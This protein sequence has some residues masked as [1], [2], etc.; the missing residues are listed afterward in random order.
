MHFTP[1][2]QRALAGAESTELQAVQ[3]LLLDRYIDANEDALQPASYREGD[4]ISQAMASEEAK[5][6]ARGLNEA[7]SLIQ[8]AMAPAPVEKDSSPA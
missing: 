4:G 7:I 1:D 8:D 5:A 2:L 3:A 6:F